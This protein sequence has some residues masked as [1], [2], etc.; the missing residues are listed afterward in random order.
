MKIDREGAEHIEARLR[1]MKQR[2][3]ALLERGEVRAAE[4]VLSEMDGLL[5][6]LH[7]NDAHRE[8]A[9][10][11]KHHVKM[12]RTVIEDEVAILG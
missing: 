11:G 12:A 5:Y 2:I 3:F 4:S 9:R 7:W 6:V 10:R 8:F 1:G